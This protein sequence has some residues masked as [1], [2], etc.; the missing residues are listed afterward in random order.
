MGSESHDGCDEGGALDRDLAPSF[1]AT[2]GWRRTAF[3]M[4]WS[5]FYRYPYN[6]NFDSIADL[7]QQLATLDLPTLWGLS[8]KIRRLNE[9]LRTEEIKFWGNVLLA[10]AC[11]GERDPVKAKSSSVVKGSDTAQPAE[12]WG[13]L[14]SATPCGRQPCCCAQEPR[15]SWP[16][17]PWGLFLAAPVCRAEPCCCQGENST[18]S[19][20]PCGTVQG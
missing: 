7:L 11:A 1:F 6:L 12:A 3:F 13:H 16:T 19:C 17:G 8:T 18:S 15:S 14:S 2:C 20:H 9:K 4:E 10:S 5:A